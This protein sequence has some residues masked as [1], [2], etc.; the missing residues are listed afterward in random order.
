M[1]ATSQTPA[2]IY[3]NGQ[4]VTKGGVREWMS[5]VVTQVNATSNR[6]DTLVVVSVP[7]GLA[8]ASSFTIDPTQAHMTL[9]PGTLVQLTWPATNTAADP[10]AT[11][12]TEAFTIK[13]RTGNALAP[14]DVVGGNRY[15]T[16]IVNT[17]PRS[18]RILGAVGIADI[19]GLP[20]KL[21]ALE[22]LLPVGGRIGAL[23]L[24]SAVLSGISAI[25]NVVRGQTADLASLTATGSAGTPTM[26]IQGSLLPSGGRAWR[27][28]FWSP[29]GGR[30]TATSWRENSDGTL[31]RVGF[32]E[33]TAVAGYNAIPISLGVPVGGFLGFGGAVGTIA[34]V[35]FLPVWSNTAELSSM[36]KSNSVTSLRLMLSFDVEIAALDVP[37]NGALLVAEAAKQ[38]IGARAPDLD[39]M[40]GEMVLHGTRIEGQTSDFSG[41]VHTSASGT[42]SMVFRNASLNPYPRG[43]VAD[44][45]KI[46]VTAPGRVSISSWSQDTA[47]NVFTPF[48][49]EYFDAVT[50]WNEFFPSVQVPKDG[51]VGWGVPSGTC[52]VN[53]SLPIVAVRSATTDFVE[54]E[55]TSTGSFRFMV[56][57]HVKE[58]VALRATS[59]AGRLMRGT[60]WDGQSNMVGTTSVV[61]ASPSY[62]NKQFIGGLLTEG[63]TINRRAMEPIA[64]AGTTTGAAIGLAY[65]VELEMAAKGLSDFEEASLWFATSPAVS[66]QNINHLLGDYGNFWPECEKSIRAM[67]DAIR[68]GG[69]EPLFSAFIWVQGY[70]NRGASR[71]S[72][73]SDLRAGFNKVISRAGGNAGGR[74]ILIIGQ[75]C[76]S[77]TD[78]TRFPEI[79]M[80]QRDIAREFYGHVFSI[81]PCEWNDAGVHLSTKGHVHKGLIAGKILYDVMLGDGYMETHWT[82]SSWGGSTLTLTM[83]GGN[84][85]YVFDTTRIPA[86]ANMGF[87]IWS[88]VGVLQDIITGVS[89][90]GSTVTLTLSRAVASGEVLTYGKGRTGV[91]PMPS[92]EAPGPYQIGNVRDTDSRSRVVDGVTYPLFN[93]CS[94]M[95]A[96]RP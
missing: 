46:Y 90:A 59:A 42:A 34:S 10:V 60:V 77:G 22:G 88:S 3:Q 64:E 58:P 23:E 35:G 18:L 6:G 31:T 7:G 26:I 91:T 39:Y 37:D 14:G 80:A 76:Q 33:L 44:G 67:G 12:G 45:F 63:K 49:I 43:G 83:R 13:G 54:F 40:T 61:V 84:G 74:P 20:A 69:H 36:D 47:Q 21:T 92:N 11:I 28:R 2:Q 78:G 53:S 86:V 70:A 50:G 87:D 73:A 85:S 55:D 32:Q 41:M 48:D 68:S 96:A 51:V 16:F 71:A 95:D 19:N 81:Y 5:E 57:I 27:V 66:G 82:V 72:Y 1:V 25:T 38:Q 56:A 15:L 4:P 29:S 93:W 9:S 89:L 75:M 52:G 30:V 94:I 17:V 65:A 24:Y 8:Q 79:P 62:G